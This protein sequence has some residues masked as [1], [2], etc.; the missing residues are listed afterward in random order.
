MNHVAFDVDEDELEAS[1]A[2]LKAAG[3]QVSCRWWSTTTT[4]RWA[5]PRK[6]HDGVWVRSVYF[7]DPNGI[8]LEF[9]AFTRELP[10]EDVAHAA[11]PRRRA[12][13]GA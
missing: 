12:G 5:S 7:R 9:A 10:P 11:G 2:R 4:A 13:Q 1:I 8:M 3:V 6:M